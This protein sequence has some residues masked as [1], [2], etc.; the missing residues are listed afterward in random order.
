M[1]TLSLARARPSASQRA[2]H[3]GNDSVQRTPV[4]T[5]RKRSAPEVELVL[6]AHSASQLAPKL[7]SHLGVPTS[8]PP[9]GPLKS[10]PMGTPP[11]PEELTA[12]AKAAQVLGLDAARSQAS[13]GTASIASSEADHGDILPTFPAKQDAV[14][15]KAITLADLYKYT[16]TA[17]TMLRAG[18]AT[19]KQRFIVLARS[20]SGAEIAPSHEYTLHAFRTANPAEPESARLRLLPSS[21]LSIPCLQDYNNIGE[22]KSRLPYAILVTGKGS[23]RGG[24]G[25]AALERDTS[26]ILGMEDQDTYSSW[27]DALRENVRELVAARQGF[28]HVAAASQRKLARRLPAGELP[29]STRSSRTSER[30]RLLP[31]RVRLYQR[32]RFRR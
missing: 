25:V 14:L 21:K 13:S 15:E 2:S 22:G 29:G 5:L 9:G 12:G 18:K 30:E 10:P 23:F 19:F 4:Y 31:L 26:W 6:G 7:A 8:S 17:S 3:T 16:F 1:T 20:K 27:I 24:R 11:L 32:A 28:S